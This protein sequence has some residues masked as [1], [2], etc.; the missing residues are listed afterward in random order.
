MPQQRSRLDRPAFGFALLLAAIAAARGG[1]RSARP[2]QRDVPTGPSFPVGGPTSAAWR[3]EILTKVKELSGLASWIYA[4]GGEA[5]RPGQLAGAIADHLD[6][7]QATAAGQDRTGR[8][9]LNVWRRFKSSSGGSSFERALGNL[10]AVEAHLLRL[11]PES[12]VRGQ[13]PSLRAHVNRYLRKDDPRRERIE[14]L[15]RNVGG[16]GPEPPILSGTDRDAL[17]AAFHAANTQRRRDLIRVRSFRNFV[18]AGCVVLTVAAIG[19]AVL[20]LAQRTWIPVC[21]FP[22]EQHKFVCPREETHTAATVDTAT[23]DVDDLVDRTTTRQDLFL[24]E[25]VGLLAAAIAAGAALRRMRGT[26]TPFGVPVALAVLKLPSGA[27]TAV[28]GLVLMRGG[29]VPGL[30]ALD[31]SAQILAWAVIF[32]YAQQLFTRLI[33]NQAHGLLDDVGGQGAGGDR[34]RKSS[35]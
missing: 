32:G 25:I 1:R 35:S 9:R 23:I 7:A 13:L 16:D 30:S 5:E 8:A 11:A 4:N 17:V 3:E 29:F 20:G 24:V 27:L 21:F 10:D 2:A 18:V 6:A 34:S 15:T 14:A 31:T 22:E 28:L 19:V 33:D 26:T 12:Y